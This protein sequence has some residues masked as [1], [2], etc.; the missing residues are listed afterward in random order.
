MCDL[1]LIVFHGIFASWTTAVEVLS[2]KVLFNLGFA[3]HVNDSACILHQVSLMPKLQHSLLSARARSVQCRV[4]IPARPE[5]SCRMF[6]CTL[7]LS[8]SVLTEAS[9]LT[10]LS[11]SL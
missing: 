2:G 6:F 4:Y 3:C 8:F 1:H 5:F 9:V 11:E 10:D 7:N